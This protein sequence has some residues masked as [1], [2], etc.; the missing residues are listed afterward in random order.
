MKSL[1]FFLDD[2][3]MYRLKVPSTHLLRISYKYA[4]G[5]GAKGGVKFP[6]TMWGLDIESTCIGHDIVWQL[7]Q[8]YK[9]LQ[10][11]NED[12]DDNLKIIIDAESNFIM[13][14]LRR[15]R[16]AKYITEVELIGTPNE[17]EKR[18]FSNG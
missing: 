5:C 13:K 10:E 6:R 3:F 18:G 14:R 7:A 17:A 1:E 9:D 11:G 2:V 15:W 4:N 8:S 16:A 12:F